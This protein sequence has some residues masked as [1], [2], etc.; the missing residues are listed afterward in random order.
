MAGGNLDTVVA[1]GHPATPACFPP[2][3]CVTS[4][5]SIRGEPAARWSVSGGTAAGDT[6]GPIAPA[7]TFCLEFMCSSRAFVHSFT[8]SFNKPSQARLLCGRLGASCWG[9]GGE[10]SR[11]ALGRADVLVAAEWAGNAQ[12]TA[13]LGGEHCSRKGLSERRLWSR[14]PRRERGPCRCLGKT[15]QAEGTRE[16]LCEEQRGG[17]VVGGE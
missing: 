5:A 13:A 16:G 17:C 8:H 2:S 3:V 6:Y 11:P 12:T 15:F 14:H 9:H 1:L 4:S 10:G 7:L